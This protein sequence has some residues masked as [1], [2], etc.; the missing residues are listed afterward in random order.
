MPEDLQQLMMIDLQYSQRRWGMALADKKLIVNSAY[1]VLESIELDMAFRIL[2]TDL[3]HRISHGQ[4]PPISLTAIDWDGPPKAP[5]TIIDEFKS[6]RFQ[7][8]IYGRPRYP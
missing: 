5:A 2:E 3:D 6:L 8:P 4:S 1:K 7:D